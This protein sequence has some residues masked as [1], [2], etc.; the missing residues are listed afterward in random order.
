M[1]SEASYREVFRE[2]TDIVNAIER[3]E[4]TVEELPD[5]VRRAGELM[6]T[7]KSK[8]DRASVEVRRV[9]DEYEME[10]ATP[11]AYK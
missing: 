1:N 2:L 5:K 9:L 7:C 3:G 4:V 11:E 6:R 8:L 10:S